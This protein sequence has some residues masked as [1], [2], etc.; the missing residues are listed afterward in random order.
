M[1]D[2]HDNEREIRVFQ[3]PFHRHE[4]Q[5]GVKNTLKSF[6]LEKLKN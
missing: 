6:Y 2:E 1:W 5:R 4:T 3:R